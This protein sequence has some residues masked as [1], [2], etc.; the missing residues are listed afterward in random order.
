MVGF[1]KCA[2]DEGLAPLQALEGTVLALGST[3]RA[4]EARGEVDKKEIKVCDL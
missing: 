2:E 1:V 3:P 4:G